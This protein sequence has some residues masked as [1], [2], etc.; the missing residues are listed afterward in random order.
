MEVASEN[1]FCFA[2]RHIMA[3]LLHNF[4]VDVR[5]LIAQVVNFV[6]L[7]FLL[8]K[9]AY[10]PVLEMLRKRRQ[11]IAEGIAMRAEAEKTL[12]EVEEIKER[13]AAEAQ[14]DA[15]AVVGRA[16]ETGAR[17]KEEI[18]AEATA[19][20]EALVAEAKVR[21]EKEAEKIQG[22][23]LAE[24]EALVREGIA[25]VLRQLPQEQRDGELIRN[26][27]AAVRAEQRV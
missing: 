13:T 10:A 12:G 20:S 22:R 26:A 24:A 27:L 17:R 3:E 23:V 15:L 2:P 8:R 1:W 25:R 9:F 21:A 4:G 6:F 18:V 7:F 11:E 5:L 19:R 16:E 14:A